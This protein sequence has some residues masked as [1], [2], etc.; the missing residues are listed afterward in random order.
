MV[1]QIYGHA[2]YQADGVVPLLIIGMA[3]DIMENHERVKFYG[4][5][6]FYGAG[7]T[8]RRFKRKFGFLPKRVTWRLGDN[9][10]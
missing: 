5:G 3:Q 10:A 6:S 1:E 2:K 4:Y 9:N 7:I 8:M